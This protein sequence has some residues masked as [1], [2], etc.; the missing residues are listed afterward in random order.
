MGKVSPALTL[1]DAA[2][3]A[4]VSDPLVIAAARRTTVAVAEL[5]PVPRVATRPNVGTYSSTE[6]PDRRP[7]W[8]RGSAALRRPPGG[9]SARR[10][11]SPHLPAMGAGRNGRVL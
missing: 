10:W 9:K 8:L 7:T 5:R 11:A 4:E 1:T 3:T 6:P 2:A